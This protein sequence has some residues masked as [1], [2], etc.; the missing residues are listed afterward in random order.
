MADVDNGSH[1]NAIALLTE[2]KHLTGRIVYS[3]VYDLGG[4]VVDYDGLRSELEKQ[5]EVDLVRSSLSVFNISYISNNNPL[6]SLGK[7]VFLFAGREWTKRVFISESGL[8]WF[9]VETHEVSA[10]QPAQVAEELLRLHELFVKDK[11]RDYRIYLEKVGAW[12]NGLSDIEAADNGDGFI[13]LRD[14]T[15]DL[16]NAAKNYILL[17]TI[18]HDDRYAFHDY[19]PIF[20]V[21][22]DVLHSLSSVSALLDLDECV[23][24][25]GLDLSKYQVVRLGTN[26]IYGNTWS[27]VTPVMPVGHDF[28]LLFFHV[29]SHWYHAQ[30]WIHSLRT[31]YEKYGGSN[32]LRSLSIHDGEFQIFLEYLFYARYEIFYNLI[33]VMNSD[34]IVKNSSSNKFV[35]F[36]SSTLNIGTQVRILEQFV[37]QMNDL[38]EDYY[39]RTHVEVEERQDK[40]S[41]TL[42]FLFALNAVVG[43]VAFGPALFTN[44]AHTGFAMDVP[45]IA[46]VI[47]MILLM[48][49]SVIVYS[50]V[51]AQQRRLRERRRVQLRREV[52]VRKPRAPK[53]GASQTDDRARPQG[54]I[55]LLH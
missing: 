4:P 41:R 12:V 18:E 5:Y 7:S 16:I 35:E 32:G 6:I 47:L 43:I 14:Q 3:I 24:S 33:D 19:R 51:L 21:S 23:S 2:T 1:S 37:A 53:G 8:I 50:A 9:V 30:S 29:H 28:F 31:Q 40:Y 25:E 20:Q 54:E 38:I 44:D 11:N 15:M 49:T 45:R 13:N 46:S 10:A 48:I 22:E 52:K 27:F 36:L 39:N 17:R 34:F 26:L 42:E 55:R